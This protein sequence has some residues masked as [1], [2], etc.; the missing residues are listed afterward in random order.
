MLHF[1]FN[2]SMPIPQ[3]RGR[4]IGFHFFPFSSNSERLEL[5]T[6]GVSVFA[7]EWP[8]K[9]ESVTKNTHLPL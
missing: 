4:Y 7:C 5:A 6:T 3:K 1:A 2:R 8:K 9:M